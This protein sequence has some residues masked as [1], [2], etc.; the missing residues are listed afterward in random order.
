MGCVDMYVLICMHAVSM[1]LT[2][3]YMWNNYL[4]FAL[5]ACLY[6]ILYLISVS[7]YVMT[8]P[9]VVLILNSQSHNFRQ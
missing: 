1:W 8:V 3:R 9:H 2:R 6:V 5:L 7:V 4:K